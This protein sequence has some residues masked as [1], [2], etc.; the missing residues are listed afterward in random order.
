MDIT[1]SN[2]SH[3]RDF[4]CLRPGDYHLAEKREAS[5]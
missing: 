2:S 4:S 5:R 3:Y 1:V